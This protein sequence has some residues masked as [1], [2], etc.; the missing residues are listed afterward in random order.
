MR[1]PYRAMFA[2]VITAYVSV[3]L[4]AGCSPTLSQLQDM[5]P[6]TVSATAFR[7]GTVYTLTHD[8]HLFVA[9]R[10]VGGG[11]SLLHHP[12]CPCLK[13]EQ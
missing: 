9:I 11:G 4:F 12:D 10:T 7:E 5:H 3:L 13:R 1:W 2:L 8:S 6:S